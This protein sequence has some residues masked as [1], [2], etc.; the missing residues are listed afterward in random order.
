MA[1]DV[2]SPEPPDLTNRG[3]PT[4]IEAAEGVE[5]DLRREELERFLRDGAWNEAFQEWA[6]YTDVTAEEYRTVEGRGLVQR[7]DVFWDPADGRL[8]SEVPDLPAEWDEEFASTIQVELSD[9]ARTVVEMLEDAYVD[10]DEEEPS[11][12]YWSEAAKDEERP[13]DD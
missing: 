8:R 9:L 12:V 7:L 13:D 4:A 2:E 6:E 3:L 1:L 10:W 5:G 11:D